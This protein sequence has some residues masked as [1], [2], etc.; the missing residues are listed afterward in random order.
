T[1]GLTGP[2]GQLSVGLPAL[3]AGDSAISQVADVHATSACSTQHNPLEQR[4]AFTYN[5]ASLLW[6]PRTIVIEDLLIVPKL[7]PGDVAGM[8]ILQDNR[9]V[10]TLHLTC[11]S[12]DTR[13]LAGKGVPTGFG[14]SIDIGTGVERV[15]QQREDAPTPQWFPDQFSDLAF[16]SRADLG[17]EGGG[18]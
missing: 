6:P 1:H 17:N 5:P 4:C 11:P 2:L 16:A 7:L 13:L 3:V 18:R 10:F 15:V 14:S 9:P 8:S 12:F